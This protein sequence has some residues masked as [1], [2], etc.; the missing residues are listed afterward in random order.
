MPAACPATSWVLVRI[1]AHC[2]DMRA[3][4]SGYYV[5]EIVDGP[6]RG[7]LLLADFMETP[8]PILERWAIARARFE[9]T[10]AS[11]RDHNACADDAPVTFAGSTFDLRAFVSEQT[12]R[13]AFAAKG[14]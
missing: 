12:A 4:P 13:E 7:S 14:C 2:P 6:Q 10:Y 3:I 1:H 5:L 11:P 9:R 8:Q